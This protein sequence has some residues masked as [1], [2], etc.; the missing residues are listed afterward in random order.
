MIGY[1]EGEVFEIYKNNI[2]L[3]INGVG[4]KIYP[5]SSSISS[6]S[7]GDKASFYITSIIKEDAFDL[8]GFINNEE[9]DLFDLIV[10]ISG[11]GP[12]TG[13]AILSSFKFEDILNAIKNGDALFFSGVPRLG[14]KNAQ[15]LII[16][17]KGKIDEV[18]A[19]SL[20]DSSE[21]TEII[22]AL[23]AFGY[24]E[25][26]ISPYLSEIEKNGATIQEKIKFALKH[27]GRK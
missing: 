15:K 12:K 21:R 13:L 24:Q 26:E 10:G 17:M 1:L 3:L 19:V 23:K 9:K 25:K 14:K 6:L 11:I 27:L 7:K 22:D 4:Y 8:Y 20:I 5:A 18:G 16:E 2:I